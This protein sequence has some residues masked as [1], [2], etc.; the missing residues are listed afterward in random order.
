MDTVAAWSSPTNE[1]VHRGCKRVQQPDSN[2]STFTPMLKFILGFLMLANCAM[3]AYNTGYLGRPGHDG[4]EP[5]RVLN[6]LNAPAI[7]LVD[8]GSTGTLL[9]ATVIPLPREIVPGDQSANATAV[10][11]LVGSRASP[12]GGGADRG[13]ALTARAQTKGSRPT[14][15]V[16]VSATATAQGAGLECIEI[17][18]FD[19]ADARRFEGQ[20]AALA[21][22]DRLSRMAV[23]GAEHYIV[24]IPPLADKDS[25]ER[26]AA[27]LR[28]LGIDDLF[29][30]SDSSDLRWA[31]SLGT[32]KTSAAARQHLETLAKK[33]VRTAAVVARPGSAG[34]TAFQL[35]YPGTASAAVGRLR[36]NFPRQTARACVP[37]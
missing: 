6:Q 16:P 27:E 10:A 23:P 3:A 21:L 2:I 22:G 19:D 28:R 37:V 33:G 8:P 7:R 29:V 32:F 36:S 5:A 30:M 20:V 12:A 26:N 14:E 25:A 13:A 17:G 4:R 24:Y 18:I 11:P 9:H 15:A 35:H 34:K 31:I 1:R